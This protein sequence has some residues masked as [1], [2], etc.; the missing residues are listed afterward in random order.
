MIGSVEATSFDV[1]RV[2][3]SMRGEWAG[4]EYH[5]LA[6]NCNCFSDELAIKLTGKRIPGWINRMAGL[7][8]YFSCILPENLRP[9]PSPT[10]QARGG[11]RGQGRGTSQQASFSVPSSS[12]APRAQALTVRQAEDERVKRAAA[13]ERRLQTGSAAHPPI[14]ALSILGVEEDGGERAPLTGSSGAR[15][16]RN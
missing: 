16:E 11:Q 9:P 8:L 6:R 14:P 7:A 3:D 1:E 13:A 4:N 2:V 12:A 10:G 15:S 5:L